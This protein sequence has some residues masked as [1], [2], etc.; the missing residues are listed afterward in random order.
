MHLYICEHGLIYFVSLFFRDRMPTVLII[1][2]Y[3]VT[4]R[5]WFFFYKI[6]ILH[7]LSSDFFCD[8]FIV[9]KCMIF[10]QT[11]LSGR[12]GNVVICEWNSRT[13][14]NGQYGWQECYQKRGNG[15][16][17]EQCKVLY[18]S[19]ISTQCNILQ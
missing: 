10:L 11:P 17:P 9:I 3:I 6:L 16:L 7:I 18:A 4:T 1:V 14:F 12:T 19:Q 5:C 13:E 2:I 8:V 15:S